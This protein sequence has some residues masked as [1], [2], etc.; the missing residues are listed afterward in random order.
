MHRYGRAI[1][2]TRFIHPTLNCIDCR[3]VKLTVSRLCDVSIM[4]MAVFSDLSDNCHDTDNPSCPSTAG[5]TRGILYFQFWS[6]NLRTCLHGHLSL[7]AR[8]QGECVCTEILY[9]REIDVRIQ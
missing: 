6:L 9:R 8:R 4:N 5:I 7:N 2:G 3:S 1:A